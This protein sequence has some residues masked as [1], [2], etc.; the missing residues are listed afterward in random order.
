LTLF[1]VKIL[2]FHKNSLIFEKKR[3]KW[4]KNASTSI[5][6]SFM[7]FY[8]ILMKM[9][10]K[11]QEFVLLFK[12]KKTKFILCLFPTK[13]CDFLKFHVFLEKTYKLGNILRENRQT[14][15]FFWKT[16]FFMC[17]EF[18]N[19]KVCKK[20]IFDDF[21]AFWVPHSFWASKK[22]VWNNTT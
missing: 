3:S 22:W 20:M 11:F 9:P 5:R 7:S 1:L 18:Q 15:D 21:T 13:K 4:K 10:S 14:V 6:S 17:C 19:Q 8:P 2:V 16:H 12:F